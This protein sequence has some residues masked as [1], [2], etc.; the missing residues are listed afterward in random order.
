MPAIFAFAIVLCS[1]ACLGWGTRILGSHRKLGWV[2]ITFAGLY[3]VALAL[4]LL[5]ARANA[6]KYE[7]GACQRLASQ[8]GL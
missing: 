8:S 1:L 6:A 7:M 2:C 4:L 3:F 5:P